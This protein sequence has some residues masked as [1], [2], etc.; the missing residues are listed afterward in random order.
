M[1]NNHI[2]EAIKYWLENIIIRFDFCPF[3]KR[4]LERG[5]IHYEVV[6]CADRE[7]QLTS[8]AEQLRSLDK[9]PDKET[10]LVIF[11]KGLESFFDYIDFLAMA[12]ELNVQLGYEGVYQLASF[13]PD[14]CFEGVKQNAGSNYTNRSPYPIIH[15]LRE[16]SIEKALDYYENPEAI[17]VKNIAQANK[18]GSEFFSDALTKALQIRGSY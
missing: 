3:A 16:T 8:I 1:K 12:N 18:L 6:E 15:I 5:S 14:Y 10:T 13:H 4:E 7:S 11:P 9:E 17:P 2:R